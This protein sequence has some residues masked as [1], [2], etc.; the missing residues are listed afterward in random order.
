MTLQNIDFNLLK[1]YLNQNIAITQ[2]IVCKKNQSSIAVNNFLTLILNL[3]LNDIKAEV[4]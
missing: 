4:N 2:F 1:H 3:Y